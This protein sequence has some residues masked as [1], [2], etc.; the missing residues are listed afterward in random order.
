MSDFLGDRVDKNLPAKAGDTGLISGLGSTR[1]RATQAC[2]P[3]TITEL[4]VLQ[5]LKPGH[6]KPIL[7]NR[8]SHCNEKP[9]NFNE[10]QPSFTA[11]RE[12]PHAARQTHP[13]R[14]EMNE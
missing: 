2:V 1:L 6:L 4:P 7:H 3:A 5:L 13:A 8:R 12:S 11:T 9:E 10:E 14:P